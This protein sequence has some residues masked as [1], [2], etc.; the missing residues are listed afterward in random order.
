MTKSIKQITKE[1]DKI[2]IEQYHE[3]KIGGY[4]YKVKVSFND[5]CKN[6]HNSFHITMD[7]WYKGRFESCGCQHEDIYKLFP[8]LRPL[9][10]WHFMNSDGPLYYI[11]NTVYLA[12]EEKDLEGARSSAMWPKGTLKQLKIESELLKRLP[13][14]MNEFYDVI[15][16]LKTKNK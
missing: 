6:G 7:T 4:R 1:L 9:I 11:V 10:R 15:I 12:K 14:L 16:G 3:R 13:A 5:D 8:K 2:E